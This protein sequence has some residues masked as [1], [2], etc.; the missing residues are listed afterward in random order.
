M[1]SARATTSYHKARTSVHEAQSFHGLASSS[2]TVVGSTL[3]P[4]VLDPLRG[5]LQAPSC[6]STLPRL[7]S[8]VGS[9]P[10]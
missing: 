7:Q 9:S 8:V 5:I 10:T 1:F 2:H 6:E 3:L 4:Q